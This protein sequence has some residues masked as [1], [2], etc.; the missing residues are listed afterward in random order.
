M[1]SR[2]HFYKSRPFAGPASIFSI[3][4]SPPLKAWQEEHA[5]PRPRPWQGNQSPGAWPE[6]WQR[7]RHPGETPPQNRNS[8]RHP[9]ERHSP[10]QVPPLGN[11][12]FLIVAGEPIRRGIPGAK[13]LDWGRQDQPLST[14]GLAESLWLQMKSEVLMR[15][16][17][18]EQVA[19]ASGIRSCL[20]RGYSQERQP[21]APFLHVI[22]L[23]SQTLPLREH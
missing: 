21:R 19:L 14:E 7:T 20:Y 6:G 5:T 1:H 9:A 13:C 16:L 3:S 23:S 22:M 12:F 4:S 11:L 8:D 18:T 2:L 10:P 15:N 17:W